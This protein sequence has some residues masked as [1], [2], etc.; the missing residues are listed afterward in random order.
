LKRILASG[1]L[2]LRD[3]PRAIVT[4]RPERTAGVDEQYL[5]GSHDCA[6]EQQPGATLGHGRSIIA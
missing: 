4:F 3:R 5:D 6:K 2:A 1:D